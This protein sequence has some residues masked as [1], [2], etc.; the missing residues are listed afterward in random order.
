[1]HFAF[2]FRRTTL[3]LKLKPLKVAEYFEK[4]HRDVLRDIRGLIDQMEGMRKNA[5][6]FCRNLQK[7]QNRLIHALK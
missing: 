3:A 1:M 2:I 4:N 7:V 5:Q 6:T